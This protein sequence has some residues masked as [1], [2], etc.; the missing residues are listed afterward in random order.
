MIRINPERRR[1][2]RSRAGENPCNRVYPMSIAEGVQAGDIYAE[3]EE[4]GG[5]VL[6]WHFCGFAY[7]TGQPS[8]RFLRVLAEDVC[9]ERDRRLVLITDDDRTVR[10]FERNGVS[11]D[12]RIEY[13]YEGGG[14]AEWPEENPFRAVRIGR[15]NAGRIT[16]RITPRFSWESDARFLERG[17]GYMA[18]DGDAFCGAAFASAVSSEEVDIGVE[19]AA[20]YRGQGIAAMLAKKMCGDILARGKRPVWACAES[21]AASRRTALRCGFAERKTEALIRVR[22]RAEGRP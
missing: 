20:E 22:S 11:A 14:D 16:G 8:E 2:Y 7:I 18:L 19:V 5:A 21:N 4:G 3:G 13:V 10:F 9:E 1:E 15:E 12:R 17:F 6:F